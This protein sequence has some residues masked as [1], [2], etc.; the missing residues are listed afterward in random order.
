MRNL[1]FYVV[2]VETR[3]MDQ[4]MDSEEAL[5]RERMRQI[6]R[7]WEEARKNALKIRD[8]SDYADEKAYAEKQRA[9]RMKRG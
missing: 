2:R 5:Y 8:A 9:F 7:Q 1:M 4:K 3:T 6:R